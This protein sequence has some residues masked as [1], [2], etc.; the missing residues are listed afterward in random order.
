MDRRWLLVFDNVECSDD[1]ARYIPRGLPKTKGSVL[2]TTRRQ[3]L[4]DMNIKALQRV[5]HRIELKPLA[6]E[7]C[8]RFL[9]WSIDPRV[10]LKDLRGHQSYSN[11]GRIAGLV[12]GLPLALNMVAGYIKASRTTL[13]EFLEMWEE[14]EAFRTKYVADR[15]AI[16]VSAWN[17]GCDERRKE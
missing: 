14:R 2:I 15:R 7:T 9:I 4:I 13:E 10:P 8:T 16:N 6:V 1:I 12:E 11:A 5:L 3:N 17:D